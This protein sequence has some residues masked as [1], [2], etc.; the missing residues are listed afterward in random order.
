M[1]NKKLLVKII[2]D[3]GWDVDSNTDLFEYFK[4]VRLAKIYKN[5]KAFA[6]FL[7]QY[8]QFLPSNYKPYH[9]WLYY[10]NGE[11][12]PHICPV[13][14]KFIKDYFDK[15]CCHACSTKVSDGAKTGPKVDYK[16]KEKDFRSLFKIER[17]EYKI[18]KYGDKRSLFQHDC[19]NQFEAENYAM[20]VDEKQTNRRRVKC[21]CEHRKIKKHSLETVKEQFQS[22]KSDWAVKKFDG[23]TIIA[24]N[25]I[26]GHKQK[27]P[28]NL[29]HSPKARCNT[30]Y[31]SKFASMQLTQDD[32]VANLKNERPEFKLVGKY[33]DAKTQ[34]QYYHKKCKQTFTAYP[35]YV[36]R[37]QFQCPAC[38]PKTCGSYRIYEQDGRIIKVRGKEKLALDHLI[39]RLGW[40]L[41][42]IELDADGTVPSVKYYSKTEKRNRMYK[43]DM[44]VPHKNLLI[45][46]K[47]FR[48]L[49]L[50]HC[51]FYSTAKELWETNC[52]KAKACIKKGYKFLMI[53][54][55]TENEVVKLPRN[56]YEYSH[57]KI[58]TF[59]KSKGQLPQDYYPT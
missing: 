14:N 2:S 16:K 47:D 54:Y 11:T 59:L 52:S 10:Y 34:T 57:E 12:K 6:D 23:T 19:G 56:W 39:N 4:G 17:P 8:T 15:Y 58:I 29:G 40:D 27:L 38:S 31:P 46:V 3:Y 43:P 18:V 51:F 35:S 37:K 28:Y 5:S 45:E 49:G 33:V 25:S 21:E 1:K 22:K 41:Y 50:N 44:Y 20:V 32:Y 48:T 55:N 7:N 26:C 30:C 24:V 42:D 53:L 36:K 13:C 9:R